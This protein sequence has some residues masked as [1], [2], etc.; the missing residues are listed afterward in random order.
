MS[1]SGLTNKQRSL[2]IIVMVLLVWIAAGAGIYS[3]LLSLPFHTALYFTVVTIES[4]SQL[5]RTYTLFI[6]HCV[7]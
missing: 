5:F 3:T 2:V 6:F 1:G 7:G 4:G